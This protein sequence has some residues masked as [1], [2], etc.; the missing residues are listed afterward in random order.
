[1]KILSLRLKNLNALK[2]EWQIDF[3]Q[4]A[5]ADNGLFAITGPTGAGKS[6]LLYAI[7]LAL[8]HETPRLNAVGGQSNELMTRHTA[9]CL[10]EVEFEVQSTVYRAFWSQRRARDKADGALQPPK[11]ELAQIDAATGAGHILTTH[12][13]DKTRRIAEITGLDFGRFTKSM[14][15]AQGGFAAFLNANANDRAELLEEL[16]GTEIYGQLS[17]AVFE[18]AREAREALART[19]AQADGVQLLAPE[20]RAEL[21][22]RH[23]QLHTA[24][25]ET[26]T[27]WA[28]AQGQH[29]WLQQ[30]ASAQQAQHQAH[31][32]LQRLEQDAPAQRLLPLHQHWQRS[33]DAHRQTQ[34]TLQKLQ[35]SLLDQQALQ[36]HLHQH[37]AQQAQAE[38]STARQQ[39]QALQA[40]MKELQRYQQQ[41]AADAQ[42]GEHLGGWRALLQQRQ[43]ALQQQAAQQHSAAQHGADVEQ[44]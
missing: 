3:R 29:A 37:A 4:P 5:F 25:A 22:A 32:A 11:V 28:T 12:S 33:L 1:M 7:C 40:A 6:T 41:H 8:Y 42:L 36:A 17:Q 14:L 18:R 13:K 21:Q 30:C 10:A 38:A 24:L 16:T 43:H 34:E 23:Q 26:Q 31:D 20:A 9:D 39:L 44:L 2:G 19:Q 27:A 35:Q 15:L